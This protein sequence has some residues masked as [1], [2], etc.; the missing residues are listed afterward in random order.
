MEIMKMYWEFGVNFFGGCMFMVFQMLIWFVLYCFF[1]AFIEFWQV[2]FSWANDLFFYD[3]FWKLFFE[4]LF[5]FGV[6][7]SLFMLFWV[8]IILIYIYYNI[9]YMDMGV[10]LVMKYMQ[11]IMLI[12]FM[13]FF[14]SFVVGLICYLLFSNLINIMQIIVI[15]NYIIDNEKINWELEVYKQKLKKKKGF[16]Q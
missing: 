9:C 7:I 16:Q 5:G 1:L 6:Y 12:M 4:I 11:Y 8:V 13:G 14:N 10:N 2:G 15:K 3:I